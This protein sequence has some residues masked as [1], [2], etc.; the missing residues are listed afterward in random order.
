MR[1]FVTWRTKSVITRYHA[2]GIDLCCCMTILVIKCLYIRYNI[3][4]HINL[5]LIHLNDAV[6][7]DNNV[8]ISACG[9]GHKNKTIQFLLRP[10]GGGEPS[11]IDLRMQT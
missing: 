2:I 6:D 10:H 5:C 9:P 1:Y 3:I 7:R 4:Y 8:P 11:F